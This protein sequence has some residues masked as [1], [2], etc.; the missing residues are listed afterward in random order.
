MEA[1]SSQLNTWYSKQFAVNM[2]DPAKEPTASCGRRALQ[3]L[4]ALAIVVLGAL[5]TLV[6]M[7][8][9]PLS[10]PI[11]YFREGHEDLCGTAISATWD[12]LCLLGNRRVGK[13]P[14]IW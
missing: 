12:G 11:K 7:V 5:E 1:L 2:Q 10:M 13:V 6:Y 4:T 3:G 8:T 9:L 14:S